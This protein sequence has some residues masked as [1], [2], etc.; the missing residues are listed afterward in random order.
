MIRRLRNRLFDLVY[1][2]VGVLIFLVV[3]TNG[4]FW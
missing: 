2:G 1:V 3:L 4:T